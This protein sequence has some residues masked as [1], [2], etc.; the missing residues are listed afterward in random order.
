MK[1]FYFLSFIALFTITQA[2]SQGRTPAFPDQEATVKFYPNPAV[3]FITFDFQKKY[4][5][6]YSV[7]L[8]NFLGKRVFEFSA[9]DQ[10]TIVNV[11][12]FFRGI[13]IFQLKDPTGRIIE[14]GKFQ[15]VK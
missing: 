12:D 15:V 10:K 13:Y 6:N 14:S 4:D 1:Y 5:K 2:K 9:E 11:S 8:Y 7:Q 3:S